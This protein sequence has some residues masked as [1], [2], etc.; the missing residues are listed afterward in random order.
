L[1]TLMGQTLECVDQFHCRGLTV[2]HERALTYVEQQGYGNWHYTTSA[3]YSIWS[4]FEAS[5]F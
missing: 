1:L 4:L 5:R 2:L 3:S